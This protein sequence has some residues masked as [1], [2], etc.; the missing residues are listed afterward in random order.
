MSAASVAKVTIELRYLFSCSAHRLLHVCV[1]ACL[2]RL[3]R[4]V[5]VYVGRDEEV[6]CMSGRF[7][8]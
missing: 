7:P 8:V 1:Y 4:M 5:C 6:E 2:S 3:T